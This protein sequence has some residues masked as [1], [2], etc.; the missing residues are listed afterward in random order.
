MEDTVWARKFVEVELAPHFFH[1]GTASSP[2]FNAK[3]L[4]SQGVPSCG[5]L[6]VGCIKQKI[7]CSDLQH[8]LKQCQ[9]AFSVLTYLKVPIPFISFLMLNSN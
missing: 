9:K 8:Q 1:T 2:H 7:R 6:Q 4:E 5:C 3:L